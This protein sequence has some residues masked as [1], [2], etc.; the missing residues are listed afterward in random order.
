LADAGGELFRSGRKEEGERF[1]EYGE[2]L[3]GFSV[4]AFEREE[5]VKGGGVDWVDMEVDS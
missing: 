3:W 4:D 1:C 5:A 2:V